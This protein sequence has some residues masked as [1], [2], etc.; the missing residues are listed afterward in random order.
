MYTY[1]HMNSNTRD[2]LL[3][4]VFGAII[5]WL[6]SA[7]VGVGSNLVI[8]VLVGIAG[9]FI[10][11]WIMQRSGKPT[12]DGGFSWQSFLVS[13]LGAIILLALVKLLS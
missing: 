5:G 1:S 10:G 4:I 2:V 6:A 12:L 11:G 13:L 7:I 9:S 3:W 8:D